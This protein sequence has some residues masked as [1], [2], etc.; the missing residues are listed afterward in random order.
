MKIIEAI[1]A[2][3]AL[4]QNT[5]TQSDKVAW[6]SNVDSKVKRLIIDTHEGGEEVTFTGYNDA[7]DLETELLVPAPYDEVYLRWLEAMI[8]YNNGEY[9]KYNNS[10]NMYNTAYAGF[11]NH[12]N[13]THMPKGESI[14]YF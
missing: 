2:I 3:D 1:S 11:Q 8:D 6:L 9:G 5:Y 4:K 10:I 13:R 12:Y 14:K 7:T